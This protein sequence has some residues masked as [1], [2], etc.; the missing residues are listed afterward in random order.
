MLVRIGGQAAAFE[1]G[2][3]GFVIAAVLVLA[4]GVETRGQRLEVVSAWCRWPVELIQQQ[5]SRRDPVLL[6][7]GSL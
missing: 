3:A 7:N 2:A 5:Y 4:L 6:F 1:V